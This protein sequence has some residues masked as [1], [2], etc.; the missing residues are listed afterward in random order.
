[1]HDVY[2]YVY[3]SIDV[4]WNHNPPGETEESTYHTTVTL[5]T[6]RVVVVQHDDPEAEGYRDP[7]TGKEVAYNVD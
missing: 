3:V 2:I 6:G 1:M 7:A 5:S 4:L